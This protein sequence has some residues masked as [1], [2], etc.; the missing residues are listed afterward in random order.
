MNFAI[1]KGADLGDKQMPGKNQE[2]KLSSKVR[3]KPFSA[4]WVF[5]EPSRERNDA[6]NSARAATKPQEDPGHPFEDFGPHNGPPSGF[7]LQPS[8]V[9]NMQR[10]AE[11]CEFILQGRLRGAGGQVAPL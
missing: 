7:G 3:L 11:E 8:A 2:G 5:S 1:K 6:P 4:S 9:I 10:A